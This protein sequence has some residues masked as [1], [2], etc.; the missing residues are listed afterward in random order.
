MTRI[1]KDPKSS[2]SGDGG[3]SLVAC[4][5]SAMAA[6][7]LVDGK[8]APEEKDS[9]VQIVGAFKRELLSPQ[10]VLQLVEQTVTMFDETGEEGWRAILS[11]GCELSVEEKRHVMDAAGTMAIVDGTLHRDEQNLIGKI[12]AWIQLDERDFDLWLEEFRERA[13]EP[14]H[15]RRPG[16]DSPSSAAEEPAQENHRLPMFLSA[17]HVLASGDSA[18]GVELLR[19]GVAVGDEQCMTMLANLHI[20]GEHGVPVD[21]GKAQGLFERAVAATNID[22]TFFYGLHLFQGN[23]LRRDKKRGLH[24]I[25]KAALMNSAAAQYFLAGY[26]GRRFRLVKAGAWALLSARNGY[27]DAQ[28]LAEG[29]SERASSLADELATSIEEL[30]Q[31]A[32]TDPEFGM[33]QLE[34]SAR[35][36]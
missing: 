34:T 12:A 20:Y 19:Q 5:V 30:R 13:P 15:I 6:V 22:G 10:E 9:L 16:I 7:A 27:E 26:H 2:D 33:V 4:M 8:L 28:S 29:V 11:Q 24:L 14:L 18:G 17:I 1:P 31:L 25:K 3:V 23:V 21:G 35:N 32:L 36:L